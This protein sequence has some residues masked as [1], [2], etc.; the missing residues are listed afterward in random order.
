MT[1]STDNSFAIRSLWCPSARSLSAACALWL[2][3]SLS[4]AV[5]AET[6]QTV[7]LG[8]S[9]VS[10]QQVIEIL[11]PKQDSAPKTRGLRLHASNESNIGNQA[12]RSLSLEVYFEFD[13]ADLTPEAMQ[14]LAPVGEALQSNELSNVAFTLEGH[15]D[16]SGDDGYNLTLSERR[17]ASVKQFFVDQYA[18]PPQRVNALGKGES[19]LI[20]GANPNSGVNRRVTIIAE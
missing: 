8:K 15:T 11:Q 20:D 5:F 4:S 12:P 2:T 19:E 3:A 1:T 17:A 7:H 14:Q 18:L 16:A 10:K 6:E 13:S 9:E